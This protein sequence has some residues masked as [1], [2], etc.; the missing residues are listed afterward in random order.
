YISENPQA[1]MTRD[2][3]ATAGKELAVQNLNEVRNI[4]H[5]Y[6]QAAFNGEMSPE[7]AMATAQQEADAA[8][9]DFR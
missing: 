1:G 9:E 4:F 5:G 7:T 6:I 8:L 2:V 3:L